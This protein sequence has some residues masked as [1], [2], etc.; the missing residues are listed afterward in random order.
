M[1]STQENNPQS[2]NKRIAKNTIMLYVRM[3][4]SIVV[5]LYTSRVV[6]QTLGIEDYGI[7][8]V[9]GGVVVMFSFLNGAMATSTSR[10]LTFEI[11]KKD[12]ERLRATFVSAFA[13]HLIIGI[14]ILALAET[15]GMWFLCEKMVIPSDRTAAAHWVYQCAIIGMLISVTQVPYNASIV[16]HE[17]MDVYAYFEL[18]N[19]FLKLGIVYL[20]LIGNIDKLILYAILMLVV[21][22]FIAFAYRWYGA[23][24]YEECRLSTK[25]DMTIAKPM[26]KFTGWALFGNIAYLGFTQGLNIILN[27]FFGPIVNSSRSIAVQVQGTV[28]S[29]W[30]NFQ[31]AVNPQI[32]KSYAQNEK[33]RLQSLVNRSCLFSFYLLLI[34]AVPIVIY[35][36]EILTIWL[37]TVPNYTVQFVQCALFISLVDSMAE[38]LVTSIKANGNIKAY[39]IVISIMF[40]I[41]LPISYIILRMGGMPIVVYIV[42]FFIAVLCFIVRLYYARTLTGLSIRKYAQNVILKAGVVTVG[43]MALTLFYK[44]IIVP[45]ST[46]TVLLSCACTA[47]LTVLIIFCLGLSKEEKTLIT[48]FI[49]TKLH[50]S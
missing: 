46:F 24:H 3:L 34:F 43:V 41:I 38:P 8:G 32:I 10:F 44:H 19:I 15:V 35:T 22:L 48:S 39:Q 20:L 7:Y 42:H 13:V 33:E 31:T 6:L 45:T 25:I 28:N 26:M 29:F 9:V 11:G 16:A 50:K 40:M 5:S 12:L 49:R 14:I 27:I 47:L 37:G 4:L 2:N 36:S 18:L 23:R 30:T 21:Q 1:E 17:K